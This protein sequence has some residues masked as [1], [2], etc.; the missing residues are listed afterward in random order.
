[1][2]ATITILNDP[3][4]INQKDVRFLE[5]GEA[6][7]DFLIE[8]YGFDGFQVPTVIYK[9]G[10]EEC[11]IIYRSDFYDK[12]ISD[13]L[14]SGLKVSASDQIT[15]VHS[16]LGT[17]VAIGLA[18]ASFIVAI[19][20]ASMVDVPEVPEFKTPTESPNNSLTGQTNIARPLQRIPD[21]YGVNRIYPDLIARSY[22]EYINNRKYLTEYL[23]VGRGEYLIEDLRTGDTLITDIVGSTATVYEPFAAP[24]QLLNVTESNEVNGQKIIAPNE[25]FVFASA[26]DVNFTSASVF[27]SE[28]ST[29]QSF[30]SLS[31][32]DNIKIISVGYSNLPVDSIRATYFVGTNT[33][34]LNEPLDPPPDLQQGDF[35]TLTGPENAG[36][37]VVDT[38]TFFDSQSIDVTCLN[39]VTRLP[40]VF[41]GTGLQNNTTYTTIM[42]NAGDFTFSSYS[43]V[44]GSPGKHVV[45]VNESTF[46]TLT[47]SS[48]DFSSDAEIITTIGPF[49]APGEPDNV[50]F[51]INFPRGLIFNNNPYSVQLKFILQRVDSGG[52][53][54]GSPE[55]TLKT[56]TKFTND[57]LNFT[58]KITPLFP[59]D[60][61]KATVERL[62]DTETSSD[63][64]KWTRLAGVEDISVS[65]FGNVTTVFIQTQATDQATRTQER[66]FNCRATRK[67]VTYDGTSVT[68]TPQPTAKF[69]DALLDELT[70]PFMGNK[71][72][73]Q[74][75]LDAIYDVQNELDSNPIYGDSL[76][77]F[78]YSFSN[79]R[80]PV[81]DELKTIA[82][83]ARGIVTRYGD[84]VSFTRDEAKSIPVS[85][86]NKRNKKPDSEQKTIRFNRPSDF[87]GIELQWIDEETGDGFTV[88]F[89]ENLTGENLKRIEAAGIKNYSQAW[90]RA[91]YEYLKLQYQRTSVETSVTKDGLLLSVNDLINSVDG[92]NV[93]SQDGEVTAISGLIVT[94]TERIRFNGGSG[95]VILRAEN[96]D[97]SSP[98]VVTE[99]SDT[100][101]GYVLSALPPFDIV[102]RG[103]ETIQKGTLYNFFPD[104]NHLADSYLVQNIAPSD[105]GYVDLTLIN[106][107]P[108]MYA[109]DNET[110]TPQG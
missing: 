104:N 9:N 91:K 50:W 17:E 42:P 71:P 12:H 30:S 13:D 61:Y 3:A 41:G 66:K 47:G 40:V 95:S 68:T 90:N 79:Q 21:L 24:S 98:I 58:E 88:I 99:R 97:S 52:T 107:A 83:A 55:E 14:I 72:L 39:K 37:Y 86:F 46:T 64:V 78:C 80:T 25:D 96:G 44:P 60:L 76:G 101:Y 28:N 73:S 4:G 23:C 81:G 93:K 82:N 8:E 94:T 51:D 20:A 105:D 1:M 89:P 69:A 26:N 6:L 2:S 38:I 62:T 33:V 22:F 36:T 57:P 103:D 15:I 77:R 5:D 54:I 49:N 87:D 35:I 59:G 108:E 29:L 16:P 53:P 63:E 67:L 34:R 11:D 32:G 56:Y 74:I 70:D 85:V 75:D 45:T 92:T 65:D 19:A 27:E 109:P 84:V 106:Y 7:L 43:F 18:I 110:P 100:E 48:C 31:P 10:L 102:I